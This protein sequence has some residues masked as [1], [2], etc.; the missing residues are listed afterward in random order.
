MFGRGRTICSV[1]RDDMPAAFRYDG[2]S[3][4]AIKIEQIYTER[5]K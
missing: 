5:S 1:F 4:I 3:L 2:T